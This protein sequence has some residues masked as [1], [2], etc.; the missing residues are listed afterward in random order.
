MNFHRAREYCPERWLP[1]ATSNPSSPF[2]EDRRDAHK[3]FSFGP[4]DCI[5]RNLAYHEMRLI[6]ARILFNFDLKLDESCSDWANQRIFAL[7][8]KPELKVYLQPRSMD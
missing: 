2:Y 7:W 3:P 4:R 5:G 1:E 6:M 8:E